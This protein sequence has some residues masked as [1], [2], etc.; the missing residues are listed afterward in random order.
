MVIVKLNW[1][2]SSIYVTNFD[3]S[4]VSLY[5]QQEDQHDIH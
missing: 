1:S 5:V 3:R 4:H 2:I